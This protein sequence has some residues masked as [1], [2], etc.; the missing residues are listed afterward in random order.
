MLCMFFILACE[1]IKNKELVLF[2]FESE[3]VLDEFHWKCRTLFSL[4]EDHAVQGRKSLKIELF[5]S[6]YPGL[7]PKLKHH[8][9]IGY[10]ALC[11]EVHNPS[12]ET[13]SLVLRID[14]KKD[15]LEYSD[16]YNKS[17]VLMPGA[18][19]LKISFDTLKTSGTDRLLELK[20]IYR[21]L[22]FMSHPDKKYV[23]Y[24]DYFRLVQT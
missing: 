5:P 10:K 15:A 4:S 6:S 24:L 11:F 14:D 21:F 1:K 18:N 23:L 13:V 7:S 17:F 2:D 8:N 3:S 12:P 20:N 19:Q 9:W 16:R 22:V